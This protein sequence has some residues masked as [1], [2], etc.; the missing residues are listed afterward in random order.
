MGMLV[1]NR[2]RGQRIVIHSCSVTITIVAVEGGGVRLGMEAPAEV[3]VLREE[4]VQRKQM[5]KGHKPR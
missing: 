5:R 4:L 3:A 1:L 2:K